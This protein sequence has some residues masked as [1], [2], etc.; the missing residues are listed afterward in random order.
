MPN[1]NRFKSFLKTLGPGILFASTAI[2][3]SHLVQSTRAGAEYGFTLVWAVVLANLFK[4]P[5][6]EFGSRYANVKKESIIDGYKDMGSWML[7]LY[8]LITLGTMFF[9]SAAVCAVTAGFMD[10]LLG[11]NHVFGESS[12]LITNSV[13]VLSGVTILLLGKYKV[14]DSLIKII[15]TVLLFSTLFAFGLALV[16]GPIHTET[17]IG[18]FSFQIEADVVFLF[19]LMGWMPTAVDLS[20]WNSLWTVERM[21]QT[22][23]EP[24]LKE[25]LFEFNFGYLASALLSLCFITLGAF[26]LF[27]S[28]A[29]L[30]TGSSAFANSVVHIFTEAIGDWSYYIIAI[31]AFCIMLGTFIAVLDGYARAFSKIGDL[32]FTRSNSTTNYNFS[33]IL[34]AIGAFSLVYYYLFSEMKSPEGFKNLVTVATTLSFLVAPVIAIANYYLVTQKSFPNHALPPRWLKVLSILG[35]IF[36]SSFTVF[37]LFF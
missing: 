24:E 21:E 29:P 30:P 9:V 10:N 12:G 1:L 11:L 2:G 35:I 15:G 13:L 5:F 4:Y 20:A 32:T 8:F 18:N 6:F 7:T 34:T 19:A 27:G 31:A 36:L 14:L 25:T 28:D 22:G 17:L 3:V 16:K 37:Y 23:Y 26:M 33:L